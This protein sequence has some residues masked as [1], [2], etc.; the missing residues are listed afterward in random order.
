[1]KKIATIL[2]ASV[3]LTGMNVQAQEPLKQ[4]QKAS[5]VSAALA[6]HAAEYAC[7]LSGNEDGKPSS[8]D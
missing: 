5:Y 2:F 1:M 8:N 4:Q 7:E 6:S 3:L